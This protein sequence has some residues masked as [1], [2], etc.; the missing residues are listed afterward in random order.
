M[1]KVNF[2]A[3]KDYIYCK[4]NIPKDLSGDK[5]KKIALIGT[6]LA[7]QESELNGINEVMA[8][9]PD[10]KD[11]NLGD[12]VMLT[13]TEMPIINIDGVAY[14]AVKEHMIMLSFDDKPE[15]EN[16]KNPKDGSIIRTKK[17]EKKALE[18]K[19]KYKQ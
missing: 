6:A 10:V 3:K 12:W 5:G 11:V 17:T 7:D 16:C 9:G 14:M 19:D 18:F 15:I 8:I 1:S 4:W 13:N 2:K